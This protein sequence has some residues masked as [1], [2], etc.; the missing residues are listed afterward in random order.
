MRINL[1]IIAALAAV[2]F[3]AACQ[4]QQN[5]NTGTAANSNA[6]T[7]DHSQHD[8]S[9]M[10]NHDMSQMPGMNSNMQM[11][12]APGAAE[13]PFDLQ[14]I[15]SMIHHHEGAIQMANMV[16]GKTQR[17]ELKQFAQKII[18]DQSKEIVQMKQW[19]EQWYAGKPSALNMEMPGM[20]GGMKI[21]NSEHMKEMDSMPPNHFDNHFLNMMT[22]HHEGAVTMAKDALKKAE[23]PEIKTLSEQ[24]IK[25]QQAEIEQMKAWKKKWEN[26][27]K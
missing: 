2:A 12:S 26:D 15:D 6:N 23:H 3:G 11:T 4:T 22:A 1:L 21:M 17:P 27:D 5:A 14:F 19:R 24:I 8:M 7:V 13:Q 18:D 9:N 16:L 25:A 20:V 10:A